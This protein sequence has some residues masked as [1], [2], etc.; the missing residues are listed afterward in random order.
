MSRMASH[1]SDRIPARADQSLRKQIRWIGTEGRSGV[2]LEAC[3]KRSFRRREERCP[4][5]SSSHS[6]ALPTSPLL[7]STVCSMGSAEMETFIRRCSPLVHHEVQCRTV[8]LTSALSRNKSWKRRLTSH[9]G[10]CLEGNGYY[11]SLHR[12]SRVPRTSNRHWMPC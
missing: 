5:G 7:V 8:R 12:E 11:G 4:T 9:P 2:A 10:T 1:I 6:R 3:M